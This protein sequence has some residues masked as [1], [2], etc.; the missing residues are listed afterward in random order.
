MLIARFA[1]DAGDWAAAR[2]ALERILDHGAS[3]S[4]CLLQA[5]LLELQDSESSE[6]QRW[7]ERAATA[8]ADPSWLC[9]TCGWRGAG[10]SAIC[11]HCGDF[12]SLSWGRPP[13]QSRSLAVLDTAL[14]DADEAAIV[15]PAELLQMEQNEAPGT[16][17]LTAT[18]KVAG[19]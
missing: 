16:T 14:R 8:A 2:R 12:D 1:I 15:P 9:G 6:V 17:V 4:A 13:G 18:E 10:W 3:V 5:R 7:L 19:D 11:P